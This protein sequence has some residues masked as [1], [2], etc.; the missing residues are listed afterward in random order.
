MP[1]IIPSDAKGQGWDRTPKRYIET[2]RYEILSGPPLGPART[3]HRVAYDWALGVLEAVPDLKVMARG[4]SLW[5]RLTEARANGTVPRDGVVLQ[6]AAAAQAHQAFARR[7]EDLKARVERALREQDEDVTP[8]AL[9]RVSREPK[10]PAEYRRRHPSKQGR[11]QAVALFEGA[12]A[13]GDGRTV[14]VTGVG[15]FTVASEIHRPIRGCQLVERGGRRWL[16]AQH[17]EEL[18]PAK[19]LDGRA[20][21]LDSGVTHTLTSSD[22]THFERPD[23]AAL[24]AKARGIERHRRRCCTR[25]SRQWRR[26]GR[27][28]KW[29]RRRVADVQVNAERHI[30]KE[31]S[32][33]HAVVGLE[34]LALA[35][36]TGSGRGTSSLP[37]T[38]AKRGLNE[39][40]AKARLAK[41]HEAGG[42]CATGRGP[43]RF[44]RRTPPS[45]A[46]RA[47]TRTG[48]AG[49]GRF[50][51]ALDAATGRTRTRTRESTS[52]AVQ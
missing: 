49:R 20:I 42:A 18:P 13:A 46:R 26:L 1:L 2:R 9:R 51:T 12:R 21:G 10:P 27:A 30:A 7:E 3:A 22:G 14:T 44:I 41:L 23:T 17:G 4:D 5:L 43:S 19:T 35:N 16:H 33:S 28:A 32:T 34:N 50:F 15:T 31:L 52:G 11:R 39:R 37:G 38:R 29:L 45:R 25:G 47:G 6:R 24:Q 8:R 40:L 48:Q 36:M